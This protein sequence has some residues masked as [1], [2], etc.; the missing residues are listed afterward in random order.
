MAEYGWWNF[1]SF[2]PWRDVVHLWGFAGVSEI[3]K[4]RTFILEGLGLFLEGE[5][6]KAIKQC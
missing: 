1:D 2:P 6:W 3:N 4:K 5:Q